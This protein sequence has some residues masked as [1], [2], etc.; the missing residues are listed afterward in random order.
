MKKLNRS[1]KAKLVE[2]VKTA[3]I[4]VLFVCS[5]YFGY[6]IIGLYR[7]QT[8]NSDSWWG[9]QSSAVAEGDVLKD[10]TAPQI[11]QKLSAPQ[12]IAVKFDD[13]RWVKNVTNS[14]FDTLAGEIDLLILDAY[15]RGAES[16]RKVGENEWIQILGENSVYA[17]Y[18]YNRSPVYEHVLFDG[19]NQ[20]IKNNIGVYNSVA[21]LEDN[22][23]FKCLK[24]GNVV[25]VNLSRPINLE[26]VEKS[27]SEGKFAF[28][29]DLNEPDGSAVVN[30]DVL[31]P[32]NPIQPRELGISV[33][34]VYTAGLNYT[35]VTEFTSGIIN[36]FG[37]NPNTIRQYV[38]DDGSLIF[39][40][41]TG[42][43]SMSP[44][45]I[46]GYKALGKTEGINLSSSQNGQKG[47]VIY[48]LYGIVERILAKSGLDAENRNFDLIL[49]QLP[50][51][52]DVD[53][54]LTYRMDYFVDGIRV[55]HSD[56]A[57]VYALVENGILTDFRINI[58]DIDLTDS[59]NE[60][61]SVFAALEKTTTIQKVT[62][63]TP[64]YKMDDRGAY[65]VWSV[66]G[67]N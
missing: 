62:A 20:E 7:D 21:V 55:E 42:T 1:E 34:R 29:L 23:F 66:K 40:G 8:I 49:T 19:K 36:I 18:S 39:V 59:Q 50:S 38:G 28:E 4:C 45:G 37:Y 12:M 46:L 11:L 17:Q 48:N 31:L 52:I 6:H 67:E 60:M 58:K 30:R 32:I 14:D 35:R 47:A 15:S 16:T 44:G 64:L 26:G 65:A 13:G 61:E 10:E 54:T 3:V 24:T 9:A 43:L 56:G 22:I 57:G 41:E 53:T 51:S 63:V 5:L 33:P 27:G 25:Q 2:R